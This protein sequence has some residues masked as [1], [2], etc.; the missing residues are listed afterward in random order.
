MEEKER[1]EEIEIRTSQIKEID[2]CLH[3]V[4]KSICK[5][6]YDSC[7]ATGFLLK[8]YIEER[9]LYCLMTNQHVITKQIIE[10]KKFIIIK[11]DFGKKWIKI[12]LDSEKRY[13]KYNREFD[14]SLVEIISEDGIK[15]KYFLLP[16]L[17]DINYI[18]QDIYVP[19]YPHG[20]NLSYSEG[21]IKTINDYELAYDA[22]TEL[23]S[24][25]SPIFLKNTTLI[26]GIHK[27]GNKYR[28]ENYGTLINSIIKYLNTKE[29]KYEN[30]EYYIG[31]KLN[32][33][34]H[35]KGFMLYKNDEIKYYG[36]YINDKRA[37]KGKFYWENGSYYIGEWANDLKHGKGKL[38]YKN[39]N[40]QYEGD[41]IA[42][43]FNGNGTYTWEDGEYYIGQFYNGL[44]YG[45][46][47]VYT[48]KG[49]VIYDGDFVDDKYEGKGKYVW[50]DG[51]YY[52][53]E[54]S[55]DLRHGK[56]KEYYK[57]GDVIYDGDFVK[58][59]KEGEGKYIYKNGDY[60]IGPW[61]NNMKFGKGIL[62]YKNGN[63]KYDGEFVNGKFEGEGKYNFENGEYY[64]GHLA[65][66][67][68]HGK[69]IIY[70]KNGDIKYKGEFVNDVFL[71]E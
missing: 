57:N 47:I 30:G 62:F 44:K 26:I 39:G 10:E 29:T 46:G 53:G 49:E 59:K 51:K 63:I 31:E 60:Y 19:Q 8:L 23:G 65:N 40:I 45:K 20:K 58:D 2:V 34:K 3:E 67:L 7:C 33:L 9:E 36:D 13:I 43:K 50:K 52:I 15:P 24:S 18:K 17:D 21:K 25:G 68:K 1:I 41:F 11:Y 70:H 32:N 35:G 5:I 16:N 69:G 61:H 71:E 28:K 6:R 4:S 66:D 22:S 12:K 55:N 37:G 38:F 56:G 64:I 14:I 27:Q 42:G 54:F 48:K